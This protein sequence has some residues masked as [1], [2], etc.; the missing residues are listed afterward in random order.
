MRLIAQG[1]EI[2]FGQF[3]TDDER[4]DFADALTGAL[5]TARGAVF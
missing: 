5:A 4:R 2:L 3:L 1:K